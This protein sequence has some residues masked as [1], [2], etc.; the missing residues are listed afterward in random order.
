[1]IPENQ[2][3]R[4]IQS[5][6]IRDMRVE[7]QVVGLGEA[8]YETGGLEGRSPLTQKKSEFVQVPDHYKIDHTSKTKNRTKKKS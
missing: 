8:P 7:C 5:K 4:G 2:L 6:R 3:A 1:M